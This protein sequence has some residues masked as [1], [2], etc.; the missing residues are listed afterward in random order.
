M[1]LQ[2]LCGVIQVSRQSKLTQNRNINAVFSA[3]IS[4][5]ASWPGVLSFPPLQYLAIIDNDWPE[6]FPLCETQKQSNAK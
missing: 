3:K 1:S 2:C 4:S 6:F 5:V